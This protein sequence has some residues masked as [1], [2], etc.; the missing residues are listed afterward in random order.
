MMGE[1]MPLGSSRQY[2]LL[3]IKR[4]KAYNTQKNYKFMNS[5][6]LKT[7]EF[8]AHKHSS[9]F[10]VHFFGKMEKG[11]TRT[12]RGAKKI[13]RC[14]AGVQPH[15]TFLDFQCCHL[16]HSCISHLFHVFIYSRYQVNGFTGPATPTRQFL[17]SGSHTA[18]HTLD[19]CGWVS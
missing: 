4:T 6:V 2:L 8:V 17:F 3:H 12:R 10:H 14:P 1:Y 13:E 7:K 5:K 9:A 19:G 11:L 15:L 18:T 16:L